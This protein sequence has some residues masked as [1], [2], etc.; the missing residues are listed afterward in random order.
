MTERKGIQIPVWCSAICRNAFNEKC[1]EECSVRRDCS[2]FE[3]KPDL[4]L[5][6]MPRFPETIELEKPQEKFTAVTVY[7]AKVID[8]L[9]GKEHGEVYIRMKRNNSNNRAGHDAP[10]NQQIKYVL[11]SFKKTFDS[12]A[13]EKGETK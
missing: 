5:S 10:A 1:V 13:T 7:L 6:D 3:E 11:E 4:R 12:D 9:Q 8:H 2:Y